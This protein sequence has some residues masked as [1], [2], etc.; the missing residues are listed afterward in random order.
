M[1]LFHGTQ[2]DMWVAQ[3]IVLLGLI[4]PSLA[5]ALILG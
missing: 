5:L 3:G 4:V 1:K 2:R